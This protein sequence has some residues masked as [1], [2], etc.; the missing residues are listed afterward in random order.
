VD[1]VVVTELAV[2]TLAWWQGGNGIADR[3][4]GGESERMVGR[5][6][7]GGGERMW[8]EGVEREQLLMQWE[9]T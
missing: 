1:N 9:L 2:Q 4:R 3:N 5:R 8:C 6:P 7:V